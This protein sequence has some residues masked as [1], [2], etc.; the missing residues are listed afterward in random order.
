MADTTLDRL[1]RIL[2]AFDAGHG[3]L[4]VAALA[5]RAELPLPTAYRWVDRLAGAGLLRRE[6]DGTVRPGLRLWE[7]ASRGAPTVPLARAAMPFLLDVQAV[8]RQHTQLAVLDDDGVL[9]L[10]RLSAQDAVANQAT[11]AGRLPTFTTSLGLV[12][13]AH[14]PAAQAERLHRRHGHELGGP[15]QP[16]GPAGADA[17]WAGSAQAGLNP[18]ADELR[19]LL[20]QVRR[21][22][23]AAVDGRIDHQ[24]RGV[25]VPVRDGAGAVVAA[26]GAVVPSAA[27]VAPGVPPLLMTAARGITRALGGDSR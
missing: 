19:R 6:A 2:G 4:T 27:S 20:A 7:L 14:A 3:T 21:E 24:T 15:V 17:A 22:G 16:P 25:S 13:L 10:E 11:V 9:V 26:L 8:L 12:L 1:I 23:F 18:T 5:R